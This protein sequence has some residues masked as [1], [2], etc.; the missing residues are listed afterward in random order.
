MANVS[1]AQTLPPPLTGPCPVWA[2]RLLSRRKQS[3]GEEATL[4]PLWPPGDHLHRSGLGSGPYPLC[5]SR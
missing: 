3:L 4:R 5:G 1:V 2:K